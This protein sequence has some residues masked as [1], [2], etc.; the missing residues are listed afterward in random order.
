MPVRHFCL[1]TSRIYNSSFGACPEV[2]YV[3]RAKSRRIA[4]AM[5]GTF[6][7]PWSPI[8]ADSSEAILRQFVRVTFRADSSNIKSFCNKTVLKLEEIG[9]Q[10]SRSPRRWWGWLWGWM[11]RFGVLDPNSGGQNRWV[12]AD[13]ECRRRIS[14]NLWSTWLMVKKGLWF[15]KPESGRTQFA[16]WQ[17]PSLQFGKHQQGTTKSKKKCWY[18]QQEIDPKKVSITKGCFQ[19]P[20]KLPERPC[21]FGG[22]TRLA[23]SLCCAYGWSI[24]GEGAN[25][26]ELIPNGLLKNSGEG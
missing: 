18:S 25:H 16:V 6:M 21:R 3:M 14:S 17:A 24:G 4:M 15:L 23:F 10:P 13:G 19:S 26:W 7:W 2:T 20:P 1:Q 9:P 22:Q 11:K 5:E 12:V 8:K